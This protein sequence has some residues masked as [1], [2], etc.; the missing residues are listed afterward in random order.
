MI[1]ELEC[2]Y[3]S[4]QPPLALSDPSKLSIVLQ[5]MC[6]TKGALRDSFKTTYS[7]PD[8]MTSSAQTWRRVPRLEKIDPP[9]SLHQPKAEQVPQPSSFGY[10]TG[11]IDVML[12]Q[13][14]PA[15]QEGWPFRAAI[16][17]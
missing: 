10:A 1:L 13:Y 4:T 14:A 6:S 16:R 11:E 12:D 15:P 17:R 8:I 9:Q 2:F 5:P 3:G 7:P